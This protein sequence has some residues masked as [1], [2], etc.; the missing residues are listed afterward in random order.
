MHFHVTYEF[1]I[2]QRQT[3]EARFVETGAQ[4]PS[5]VTLVSR[6]HDVAGRRGFMVVESS[7][8]TAVASFIRDWTDL[9][10]FQITPVVNDEQIAAIIG[11]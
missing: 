11:G 8:A 10:T 5:G 7:D 9:I 6:W 2:E 3:A 1:P 4:P